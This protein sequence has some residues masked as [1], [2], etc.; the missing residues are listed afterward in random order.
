MEEIHLVNLW[1][2]SILEYMNEPVIMNNKLK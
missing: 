2:G 1:P